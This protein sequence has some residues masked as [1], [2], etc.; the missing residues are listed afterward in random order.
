MDPHPAHRAYPAARNPRAPFP[1]GAAFGQDVQHLLRLQ[2][3]LGDQLPD[4]RG[5]RRP[6][7][8]LRRSVSRHTRWQRGLQSQPITVDL[9]PA[10]RIAGWKIRAS[11]E[12]MVCLH[13][14]PG[15][16]RRAAALVARAALLETG[17]RIPHAG[18]L[19]APGL[20]LAQSRG[21]L[22]LSAA[23]ALGA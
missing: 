17:F 16:I 22:F 9:R 1:A 4:S 20:G 3:E 23:S 14:V 5:Q 18:E 10:R 8:L 12:R 2:A 21:L 11:R 6:Y 13:A 19:E 15:L 7:P